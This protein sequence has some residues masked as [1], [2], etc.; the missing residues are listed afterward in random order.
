MNYQENV[1]MILISLSMN[2]QDDFERTY[3]H[4]PLHIFGF[5]KTHSVWNGKV[6]IS[7]VLIDFEWLKKYVPQGVY[8]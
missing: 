6:D 4:R 8:A 1:S 3:C 7:K 2:F 5:R